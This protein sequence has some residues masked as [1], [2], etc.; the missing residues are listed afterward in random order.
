[1]KPTKSKS[2]FIPEAT[3]AYIVENWLRE[4]PVLER[5]REETAPMEEAGM[6]IS[7]EQGQFMALLARLLGVRRY[8]EV[9]VFTGYSSIAVGLAMPLEGHIVACDVSE[10]FTAIAKRYWEEAGLSARIDLRLAPA[11]ET[12]ARLVEA[13][14]RFDMMFIDADKP[15]YAAYYEAGLRLVRPGGLIGIDN[16]LWSGKVADPS[17]DDENT[18]AIRA[19]NER[20]SN[21]DR[22]DLAI[23]PIGDGL[24]LARPR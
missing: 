11:N 2:S 18:E 15:N 9:G 13:G 14:E 17:V 1:M 19:L 8:L 4:P 10:D 6:Q 24:T 22:I 20:L 7:P 23:V 5:L 12:L 3:Y 16:V 21:D